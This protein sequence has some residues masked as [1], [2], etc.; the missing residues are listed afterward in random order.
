M[1]REI[2]EQAEGLGFLPHHTERVK[3]L[4]QSAYWI[5][6]NDANQLNNEAAERRSESREPR[7]AARFGG[8]FLCP[9]IDHAGQRGNPPILLYTLTLSY[10]SPDL[11][12][13]GV[14]PLP[15]ARLKH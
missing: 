9:W 2:I 1:L 15:R 7:T 6:A 13:K 4:I 8:P 3:R 14:C 10:F 12:S 5:G 11:N